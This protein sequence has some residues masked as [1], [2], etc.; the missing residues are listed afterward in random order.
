MLHPVQVMRCK[1]EFEKQCLELYL[2]DHWE[3]L[4]HSTDAG[5]PSCK[6]W[7]IGYEDN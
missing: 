5:N 3:G 4:M 1:L 7:F 2:L 6:D